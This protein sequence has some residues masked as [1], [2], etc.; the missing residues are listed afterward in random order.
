MATDWVANSCGGVRWRTL[1][2]GLIEIEG[3]GVPTV[4]P[5]SPR[6]RNLMQT[7]TNWSG[8]FRSAA[9]ATGLPVSWLLAFATVET[10]HLSANPVAQARAVSPV[11]ALGVMQLLPS[12]FPQLNRDS[13]LEPAFNIAH[14]ADFIRTLCARRG[15]CELPVLGA[16]YNA[17]HLGCDASRG[18]FHFFADADY[19]TQVVTFSN[20]ALT[21]L[22][23]GSSIW[24][25]IGAGVL[26]G[27]IAATAAL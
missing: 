11:G 26:L 16:E 20:A 7:W 14:G 4:A 24:P 5:G 1:S 21:S 25:W 9:S 19:P 23:L 15:G 22:D 12:A 10:G 2:S 6:F 13:L 8:L 27:A 17:G 3:D 18:Q